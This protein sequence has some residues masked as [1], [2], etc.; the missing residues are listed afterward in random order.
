M[1]KTLLCAAFA[2]AF[3]AIGGQAQSAMQKT[4]RPSVATVVE[5]VVCVGDRR[6]YRDYRHCWRVNSRKGSV[7]PARYCSRICR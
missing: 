1:R 6:D 4:D 7:W 5:P 2:M 3:A